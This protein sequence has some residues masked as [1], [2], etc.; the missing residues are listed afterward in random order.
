LETVIADAYN[1]EL[2]LEGS[3][4]DNRDALLKRL[5]DSLPTLE[6]RLC[7]TKI[8]EASQSGSGTGDTVECP[9]TPV[10]EVLAREKLRHVKHA[11]NQFRD[12]RRRGLVHAR[13][14]LT[15]TVTVTGLVIFLIVAL[16]VL[17]C[18]QRGYIVAAAAFYLVGAIVGLF[19][20]LYLEGGTETATEDYGLASARL[21]HT[22]MISGLAALGGVLII[23][24]FSVLVNSSIHGKS[25]VGDVLD[26]TKLLNLTGQPF[27]IVLAAIFGL[28]P[29]ILIS[30]LQQE[31][32]QY[33]ADL[34]GTESPTRRSSVRPPS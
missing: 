2:R 30:R 8:T 1:D 10:M 12:E 28:S 9:V 15:K 16:A 22:P 18:V 11:I 32:E 20:Q 26:L 33:K 13:N 6:A 24:M 31:A 29:T 34:K 7:D 14:R 27:S 17:L 25:T 23:P 21:F 19:N 4:I 5:R 3:N